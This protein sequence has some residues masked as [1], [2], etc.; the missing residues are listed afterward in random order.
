MQQ[1]SNDDI[2]LHTYQDDLDGDDSMTDPIMEEIGQDPS[3]ELGVPADELRAELDKED[4]EEDRA[5]QIED[6]D[7]NSTDDAY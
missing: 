1:Q 6:L 7:D 3:V 4:D 5:N 2:K